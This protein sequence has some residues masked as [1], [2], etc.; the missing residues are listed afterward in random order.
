MGEALLQAR[1]EERGTDAVVASAGFLEG[2]VP[3][4]E[5]VID[6]MAAM[7]LDVSAHLSHQVTPEL[8]DAADLIVAMTRQH[9]IDATLMA[10]D[11][12]TRI[13]QLTDLV[14]RA[15]AV[16]P[17]PPQQPW[18]EWLDAVGEGRTRTGILSASLS[19]DIADPIGQS[20]AVHTASRLLLD[21]LF[22]RL[23]DLL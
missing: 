13:F 16:G 21:D 15:E 23:A 8:L 14:R 20:A 6:T 9:V 18:S 7:G 17:W 2:G 11:A 3:P 1:L 12:W 22:T 5:E 4:T 10:P 19:D